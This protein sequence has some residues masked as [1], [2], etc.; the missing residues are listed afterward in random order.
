[1]LRSGTGAYFVCN[2][3][4]NL[5]LAL[6]RV[7]ADKQ[8]PGLVPSLAR[9]GR[10]GAV[11]AEVCQGAQAAPHPAQPRQGCLRWFCALTPA[12]LITALLIL[13]DL[14]KAP[15]TKPRFCPTQLHRLQGFR[16]YAVDTST[17]SQLQLLQDVLV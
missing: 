2:M 5:L 11:G 14:E 4:L 7:A 12:T 16:P 6:L 15:R 17:D 13:S 9:G 3:A 10:A 1:M 8:N